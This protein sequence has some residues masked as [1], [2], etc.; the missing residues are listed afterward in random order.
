MMNQQPNSPPQ[1]Q[2]QPPQQPQQVK[3]DVQK[4]LEFLK[5]RYV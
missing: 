1:Q 5:Y 2:Q 4:M 3:D